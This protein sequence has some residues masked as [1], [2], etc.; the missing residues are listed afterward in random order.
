MNETTN[1]PKCGQENTRT[2]IHT[3]TRAYTLKGEKPIMMIKTRETQ[4]Y[5]YVYIYQESDVVTGVD[6]AN[7]CVL[8]GG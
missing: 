2:N 1:K 8:V 4:I 5:I 7:L 3:H 6:D